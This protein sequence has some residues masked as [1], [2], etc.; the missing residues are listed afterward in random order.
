MLEREFHVHNDLPAITIE[1]EG[2]GVIVWDAAEALVGWMASSIASREA[3][4]SHGASSVPAHP[5]AS[6][7][8]EFDT[9]IELGCSTGICG[10][11][12][13]MLG[14]GRVVATDADR[15]ALDLA[16]KNGKA[17][18]M[19]SLR[20]HPLEW[21]KEGARQIRPAIRAA[22]GTCSLIVAADALSSPDPAVHDDLEDTLRALI[23]EGGCKLV[24]LSW[25]VRNY[26]EETYLERFRNLGRVQ[27]VWR[28]RLKRSKNPPDEPDEWSRLAAVANGDD[29]SADAPPAD[30]APFEEVVAWK[31]KMSGTIGIATLE[32]DPAL[33]HTPKGTELSDSPNLWDAIKNWVGPMTV[34]NGVGF[35]GR[36]AAP[37]H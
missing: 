29:M 20:T 10:I 3:L 14:C 30:G 32:V 23:H 1:Q 18:K 24:V 25:T 2:P 19:L 6:I 9:A 21:G 35:C 16:R 27:T 31:G 22:G 28:G 34:T 8:S 12:L 11:T 17:N 37:G 4:R 26:K 15:A 36:C 33:V 7:G 13:A 5:L